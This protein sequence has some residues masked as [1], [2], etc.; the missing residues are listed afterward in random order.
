MGEEKASLGAVGQDAAHGLPS[1]PL[2]ALTF[3]VED[4]MGHC[5]TQQELEATRADLGLLRGE[6]VPRRR[7]LSPAPGPPLAL[8]A[9]GSCHPRALGTLHLQGSG[10]HP[11][12]EAPHFTRPGLG[13]I[14]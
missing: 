2:P 8:P 6:I 13:C 3:H 7:Y 1:F 4:T 11:L 14:G 12:R 10:R 9:P 5:E